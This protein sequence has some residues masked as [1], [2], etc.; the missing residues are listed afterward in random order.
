MTRESRSFAVALAPVLEYAKHKYAL[1]KSYAA[2][3]IEL[4][5]NRSMFVGSA[6][7]TW[8]MSGIVSLCARGY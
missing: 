5:Q 7:D 3:S 2:T 4:F 8:T 6:V 1:H